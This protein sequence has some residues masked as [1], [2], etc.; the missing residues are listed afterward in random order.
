VLFRER[1]E[2]GALQIEVFLRYQLLQGFTQQDECAGDQ[3]DDQEPLGR[4][5]AQMVLFGAV[6]AI[7]GGG[8]GF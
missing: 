3:V 6:F 8:S 4:A 5:Q 2:P 1:S 7:F